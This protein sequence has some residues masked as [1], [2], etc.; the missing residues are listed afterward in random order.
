ME[1]LDAGDGRRMDPADFFTTFAAVVVD[2]VSWRPDLGS[3]GARLANHETNLGMGRQR[4]GCR[5]VVSQIWGML[6]AIW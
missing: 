2:L 1:G 6:Y 4:Q 5:L 3:E